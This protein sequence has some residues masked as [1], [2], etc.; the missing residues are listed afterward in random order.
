MEPYRL[1]DSFCGFQAL[2]AEIAPCPPVFS[3]K[4][5]Y[6]MSESTPKQ[7]NKMGVMPVN[8]LLVTMSVP[9]ILSM[10]VQALY[11]VVDSMFVARLN[12]S[13]LTAVSLVFPIQNLMISVATGTGVGINALLSRSLGEKNLQRANQ[14]AVNGVFLAGLSYLA[15]ALLGAVGARAFMAVQTADAQIVGY[16]TSYLQIC[17]ILSFGLFFQIVFERLLQSTG[18]TLY[19]MCTQMLGAVINIVLDPIMIFGLLG[20]PRM[21]VAGAALATVTGQIIASIAALILNRKVNKEIH[22]TFRRFRPSGKIIREIYAVG[23]P[24][25]IMASIGSVMTFGMNRI[26]ISFTTTATAVFGVYF[27]LQSFVFMPVFGL[28][29][30]MVPIVAYNY[31]AARPKRIMKTIW[32][33]IAYAVGIMLIGLAVFQLIPGTLLDIF[34]ASDEM[35][36]IGIPALRTISLSFLIAGFSVIATSVFQALSHGVL[37]L[38]VSLIRQLAVL[39]PVAFL[40][41]KT[42]GLGAI[43]WAFPIAEL[44]ALLLCALFLRYVYKKQIAP[45]YGRDALP[46]ETI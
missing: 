17:C 36:A 44:A 22:L 27:K 10:L 19:T 11:N 45:L 4:E 9:M 1:I 25:I 37:S 20:F 26:L 46:P 2:Y 15:F 14:A 7:E 18:R 35:K 16:G 41:S 38:L 33:S 30:G 23:V 5:A 8:R 3:K 31:G 32:L 21:E 34:N 6:P 43:W 29:N 42:G 12:E 39:L 28:N 13:A 40:L 24:S